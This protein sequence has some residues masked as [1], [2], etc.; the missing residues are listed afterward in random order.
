MVIEGGTL[1]TPK[2]VLF[3][4]TLVIENGLIAS[5]QTQKRDDVS[6]SL[7]IDA[8]GLWVVPGM[9]DIHVHGALGFEVIDATSGALH[10]MARF[11]ASHG[12]TGYLPTTTSASGKMILSAIK[13]VAQTSQ[14]GDGAH[15]LGVHLEGPYLNP[16]F[17]G[18]QRTMYIRN[19]D[20][21]EFESWLESGVVRLVTLAPEMEGALDIIDLGVRQGV[22][23]AVGHSGISC[24]QLLIAVDRGLRHATHTF[25]GMP[26]MHHRTPGVVGGVLTDDRIWAQIICDGLHVHPA[27]VKLLFRLKGVNRTVLITDAIRGAGLGDA[28]YKKLGRATI[29]HDGVARTVRGNLA[30]STISLDAALRN[31]ISFCGL[32]LAQALPMVTSVP[33]EAIGMT[34]RKGVL[35]P[36]ADGDIVLLDSE[37]NVRM[38]IIGGHVVYKSSY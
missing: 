9:I 27:V 3:G 24:E 4:H 17:A 26:G 28:C 8:T 37:L 1:I 35:S 33:A 18:A 12:V 7:R 14:P 21:H 29:V 34:G 32:S 20:L 31:M 6:R 19:P 10:G 16:D 36:G 30:G 5:L 38:T 15:H 23:F 11:F 2:E 25:N 13:N 22:E